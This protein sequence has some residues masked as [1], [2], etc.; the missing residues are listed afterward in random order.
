MPFLHFTS[1]RVVRKI[2]VTKLLESS[3]ENLPIS[4]VLLQYCVHNTVH[5]ML[6]ELKKK[7]LDTNTMSFFSISEVILNLYKI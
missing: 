1:Q 3:I 6:A 5:V 4:S 7:N 2:E